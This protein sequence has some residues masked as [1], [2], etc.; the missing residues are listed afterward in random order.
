MAAR[1]TTTKPS[2]PEETSGPQDPET[3][4]PAEDEAAPDETSDLTSVQQAYVDAL[5][6]ERVGYVRRGLDTRVAEVDA[7]LERLGV[8]RG[9]AGRGRERA[10]SP[11]TERA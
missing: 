1:R 5:L 6:R 11:P 9:Q 4:E 10:V 2:E 8:S 3:S 7:E